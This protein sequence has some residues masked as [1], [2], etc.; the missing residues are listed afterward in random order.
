MN[1]DI[2]Q[3]IDYLAKIKPIDYDEIEKAINWLR[4]SRR[5]T[6]NNKVEIIEY[7]NKHAISD[8]RFDVWTGM[9]FS[10]VTMFFIIAVCGAVLFPNGIFDIQ[11]AS[12]AAEALLPFVGEKAYLLFTLGIVGTGLLAVPVLAGSSAYA[13][14]ETFRCK[15]D[16]CMQHALYGFGEIAWRRSCHRLYERRLFKL[17]TT[18]RF[19]FRCRGQKLLR[20]SEK[21]AHRKWNLYL[22]RVGKKF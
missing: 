10:N 12:Q 15:R 3:I 22:H 1:H 16:G 20:T 14:A 5:Q 21:G 4:H 18:L 8:M 11:T 2:L 7:D 19:Y 17:G 13:I 9:F 6:E